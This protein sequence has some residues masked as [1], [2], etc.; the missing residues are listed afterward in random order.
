MVR[1]VRFGRHPGFVRMVL[2]SSGRLP[3]QPR[4]APD[5]RSLAL[6][7]EGVGWTAPRSW[8]GGPAAL[9]TGYEVE[10]AGAAGRF[11]LRAAR[12]LALRHVM[13]LPPEG[14]SGHRLVIDLAPSDGAP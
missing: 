11:V 6:T 1:A 13:R 5:G 14:N 4:L 10:A 2:E 9:L 8:K 12:P 3:A 7:L